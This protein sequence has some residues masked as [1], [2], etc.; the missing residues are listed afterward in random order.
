MILHL[1]MPVM[2]GWEVLA[3]LQRTSGLKAPWSSWSFRQLRRRPSAWRSC[4]ALCD[5]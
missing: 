3:S 2:S 1:E 5:R 4:A